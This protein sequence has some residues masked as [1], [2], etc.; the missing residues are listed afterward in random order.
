MG[1]T[2]ISESDP[3]EKQKIEARLETLESEFANLQT[4][5]QTRMS[6]LENALKRATVYEDGCSS[7]DKW[8]QEAEE[9]LSKMEPLS[10]A[11]Q[12]LKR[13]LEQAREFVQQVESHMNEMDGVTKSEM[14]VFDTEL[15]SIQLCEEHIVKS[16]H[17]RTSPLVSPTDKPVLPDWLERPGAPEVV[18]VGADLRDRYDKLQLAAAAKFGEAS[19]LMEKVLAYEAEHDK[20]SDWLK[21]E[22]ATI[23]S[24]AP[25]PI[26]VEEVKV[27][28]Q[29]TE[30]SIYHMC[31][32]LHLRLS[33][34]VFIELPKRLQ[35]PRGST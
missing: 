18:E 31:V 35:E 4:A 17:P 33:L 26:T 12:P 5:A 20:F 13:Q 34:S 24:F 29:E 28:I 6:R 9:Q 14:D 1:Q 3:E 10:V 27:Q 8:L 15:S 22:K 19:E 21:G 11:S 32:L 23:A 7:F 2:L 25:P 16:S 30:V